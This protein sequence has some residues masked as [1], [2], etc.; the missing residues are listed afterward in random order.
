MFKMKPDQILELCHYAMLS[1]TEIRSDL[2][3]G[4]IANE[5]D[6]TSN[7]TGAFRRNINSYSKTG[8]VATSK[9]LSASDEQ[10]LGCDAA[11]IITSGGE[12][13]IAIF[14]AKWP[15]LAKP[16][17]SWDYAQ[18]STG[19][20]HYSDQLDRQNKFNSN[21]AIFEI[22]YC[23][24]P[25]G[26]QPSYMKDRVSSC[27]WHDEAFLFKN[28]RMSPDKVWNRA[29]LESLLK[30]G[31]IKIGEVM[32]QICQCQKGSPISMDNYES[33]ATEFRL[34]ANILHIDTN[35]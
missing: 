9:V 28:N 29:D 4:F 18:T 7:F 25:F 19:L 11:I 16:N 6:Y 1:D 15:R 35:A 8:L 12:S 23:E 24:Y 32:E 14:E 17:Y 27:I 26:K 20:S 2:A 31:N 21:L 30:K 3:T 34:P 10:M 22:F 5:D 13:K 33:I